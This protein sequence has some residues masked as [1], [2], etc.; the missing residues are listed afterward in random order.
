MKDFAS[1]QKNQKV[2]KTI[3]EHASIIEVAEKIRE[4]E[5]KNPEKNNGRK[6]DD[7]S[8]TYYSSLKNFT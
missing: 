7:Q 2:V 1:P 3:P 5:R 8:A 6:P 4:S